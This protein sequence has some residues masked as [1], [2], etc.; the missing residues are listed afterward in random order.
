M[1][2]AEGSMKGVELLFAYVLLNKSPFRNAFGLT[3]VE[4]C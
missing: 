1:F 2:N 3:P 4:Q